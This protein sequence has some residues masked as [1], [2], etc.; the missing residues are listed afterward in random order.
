MGNKAYA[1]TKRKANNKFD[2]EQKLVK[3]ENYQKD[4]TDFLL[5][6]KS[7]ITFKKVEYKGNPYSL[8]FI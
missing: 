8:R 3:I 6:T 2:K 4:M 7:V 5:N 1:L